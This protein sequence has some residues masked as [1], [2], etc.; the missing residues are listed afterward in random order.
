MQSIRLRVNHDFP[1]YVLH[2]V[3]IYLNGCYVYGPR[4][5][6]PPFQRQW[7]PWR[8]TTFHLSQT[9]SQDPLQVW[10]QDVRNTG[11]Y[12]VITPIP[13]YARITPIYA[14][15]TPICAVTWECL[16][17]AFFCMCLLLLKST[18]WILSGKHQGLLTTFL[19]Q[20]AVTGL[21]KAL[22]LT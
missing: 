10:F 3:E 11:I 6:C 4:L 20:Q 16:V 12:A 2:P 8:I 5:Q 9:W 21:A 18:F 7:C 22:Q 19:Q 17:F 14:R 13:I 15:I 1:T